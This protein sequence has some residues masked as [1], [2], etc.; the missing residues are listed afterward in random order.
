MLTEATPNWKAGPVGNGAKTGL[1]TDPAIGCGL[2]VG[3][4]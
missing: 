1:P 3:V 4:M 2:Q